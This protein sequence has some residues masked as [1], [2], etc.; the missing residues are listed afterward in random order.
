VPKQLKLDEI[1]F[2]GGAGYAIWITLL[3]F[4]IPPILFVSLVLGIAV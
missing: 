4:V 1:D 3:R 2:S